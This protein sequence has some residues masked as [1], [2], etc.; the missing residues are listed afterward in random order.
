MVTE[1]ALLATCHVICVEKAEMF[2]EF[3]GN[4]LT[5]QQTFEYLKSKCN[6]FIKLVSVFLVGD[7]WVGVNGWMG[8]WK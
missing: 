6:Q 7:G 1:V 8:G 5:R 3:Y 4:S 2:L